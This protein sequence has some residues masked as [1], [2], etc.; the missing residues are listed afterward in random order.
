MLEAVLHLKLK[1]KTRKGTAEEAGER[2][3]GVT[4]EVA[5]EGA[6]EGTREEDGKVSIDIHSKL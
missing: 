6:E 2:F 4:G 1:K 3:E 5:K